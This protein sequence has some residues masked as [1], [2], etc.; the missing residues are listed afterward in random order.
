MTNKLTFLFLLSFGVA[1]AQDSLITF[2]GKRLPVQ[3][4]IIESDSIGYKRTD[5]EESKTYYIKKSLV[6]E[7]KYAN[8]L[9]QNFFTDA[10][11]SQSIEQLK[12]HIVS[13]IDQY[14]YEEDSD[15]QNTKPFL[16][17]IIYGCRS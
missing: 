12:S 6:S 9:T 2:R 3:N 13:L 5:Y 1:T 16:K 17:A 10:E 8:G 15:K 7:I 14:G 4:L 11:K